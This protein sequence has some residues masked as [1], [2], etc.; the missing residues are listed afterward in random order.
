MPPRRAGDS[1]LS[2]HVEADALVDQLVE[3]LVD[4][5]YDGKSFGVVVLQG[6]SQVDA[7]RP[8]VKRIDIEAVGAA[9]TAGRDTAGLPGRRTDVVFLSMV[10]APEQ[11][12]APLTRTSTSGGSTSRRHGRRTSCGCS[13]PSTV[14]ELKRADLRNSLLSYMMSTSPAPADPMPQ[15][16]DRDARIPPFD[17]LF[18]QRVFND[19]AERGY[20]VN[21]QVEV[22]NRRIDLVVTGGTHE[23]RRRMRRRRVPTTPEQRI[24][25]L[26]REQE[27]KRC[28]WTFWRV[29]ESEYY[30]DPKTALSSLWET[31]GQP[32]HRAA[33]GRSRDRHR[34]VRH[35]TGGAR[36]RRVR[37]RKAAAPIALRPVSTC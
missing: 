24:A 33:R 31:S 5:R 7:I 2:N 9:A 6:Q 30:L 1:T 13:T 17:N 4:P 16:V 22:N 3:C 14:D 27:L 12:F 18:E 25:D 34:S 37:A 32:G 36:R 11:N 8:L 26:E 20:H 29:R 21:S 28:G 10:V 19:I 15:D 35:R 23:A